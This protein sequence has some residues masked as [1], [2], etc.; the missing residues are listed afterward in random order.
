MAKEVDVILA[1]SNFIAEK[2]NR[3]YEREAT[4]VYPPIDEEK[5]YFDSKDS[6]DDYF[7]MV[8]RFLPYKRFD[9][10]AQAFKKLPFRLLIAGGGSEENRLR[11]IAA[12]AKNITFLGNVSDFELRRLYSGA[13]ALIF[14]SVEDFGL[15]MAEA[16]AC[17]T[18]VI[19]FA[20]GGA[21]EIIMEGVNGHFFEEQTPEAISSAIREFDVLKFDKEKIALTANR[22]SKS[23]FV[24]SFRAFLP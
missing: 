2:I 24:E 20:E 13:R 15:V 23:R 14:P 4:V 10:V 8:G 3:Y 5:F 6:R 12:G 7:F 19:A 11:E 21:L 1:N 22:F 17:G 9:L 18:P 16:N